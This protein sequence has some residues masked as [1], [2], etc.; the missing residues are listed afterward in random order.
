MKKSVL[1]VGAAT[2]LAAAFGVV[3]VLNSGGSAVQAAATTPSLVSVYGN[4]S[5]SV[6]PTT[7]QISVSVNNQGSTAQEALNGNN[8]TA[9]HVIQAE[10]HQ[11]VA[12]SAIATAGLNISPVDNQNGTQITGYQVTDTLNITTT[13]AGAGKAV[14]AAVQAGANQVNGINFTVPNNIV[15]RTAY[16]AAMANAQNQAS[17]IAGS[18]GE[19]VLG[20]KSVASVNQNTTPMPYAMSVTGAS[21]ARTPMM[22]G[23]STQSVSVKV[24][25]IIG[26]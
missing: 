24:V 18:M 10:E 26:H 21:A 23:Q 11:G 17:A 3:A 1:G 13:A 7:A 20:V 8:A 19:K 2:A 6:V 16:K 14:D 22:P 9:N 5:V 25:Y 12:K 15:Y 4:G